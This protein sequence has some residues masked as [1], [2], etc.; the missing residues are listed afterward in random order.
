[1][2]INLKV[3][4]LKITKPKNATNII[5]VFILKTKTKIQNKNE[6]KL[7]NKNCIFYQFY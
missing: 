4:K 1:M 6:F 2:P 3:Q 7:K 5:I